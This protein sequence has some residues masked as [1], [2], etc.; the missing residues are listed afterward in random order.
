MTASKHGPAVAFVDAR[1]VCCQIAKQRARNKALLVLSGKAHNVL[2]AWSPKSEG[3]SSAGWE[4]ARSCSLRQ[5]PYQD[6]ASGSY[7]AGET[8]VGRILLDDEE[9][10]FSCVRNLSS[11]GFS[12][13]G[14]TLPIT[15]Y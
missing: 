10:D 8:G 9:L 13:Q 15:A 7:Q 14:R 12:H 3:A 1:A 5:R 2:L 4:L 11:L 6:L